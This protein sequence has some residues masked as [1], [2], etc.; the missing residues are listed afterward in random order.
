MYSACLTRQ[1]PFSWSMDTLG[2]AARQVQCN[3]DGHVHDV[4]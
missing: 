3:A 1:R 4:Q 2:V